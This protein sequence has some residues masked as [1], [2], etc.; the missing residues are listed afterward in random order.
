LFLRRELL[1]FAGA[2]VILPARAQHPRS[3]VGGPATL[4]GRRWEGAARQRIE[5]VMLQLGAGSSGY[6]RDH[7]AYA[8]PERDN[9]SIVNDTEEAWF[10]FQTKGENR[11]LA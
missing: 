10:L 4:G 1:Q 11:L 3:N 8:A 9:T 6:D 5:G 2:A 7:P